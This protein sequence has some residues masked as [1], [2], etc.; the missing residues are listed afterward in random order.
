VGTPEEPTGD[1]WT[2]LGCITT[3]SPQEFIAWLLKSVIG[4]AGGIAFLLM[5]WGGFQIITS[6]GDPEKL[7]KGK[8]IL[9]SAIIGLVVIIFSVFLLK[10]IGVDILQLPGF[11]K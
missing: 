6:T 5:L 1:S 11:E 10:L 7:N 4:I 2:A 9:T 8:E 3:S